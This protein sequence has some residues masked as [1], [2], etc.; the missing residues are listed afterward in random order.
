MP[1]GEGEPAG[2]EE[3]GGETDGRMLGLSDFLWQDWKHQRLQ[4][5]TLSERRLHRCLQFPEIRLSL[6][7]QKLGGRRAFPCSLCRLLSFH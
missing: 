6:T 3:G 5:E 1:P 4:I 7:A 2:K